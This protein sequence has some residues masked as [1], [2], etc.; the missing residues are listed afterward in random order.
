MDLLG[1]TNELSNSECRGTSR[2]IPAPN[3][4]PQSRSCERVIMRLRSF[5]N[6]DAYSSTTLLRSLYR[7]AGN[8]GYVEVSLEVSPAASHGS[9][10]HLARLNADR[11][12]RAWKCMNQ[13]TKMYKI[14]HRGP[15]AQS[16]MLRKR[17]KLYD[18]LR[19]MQSASCSKMLLGLP[20]LTYN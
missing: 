3:R 1:H 2:H 7:A 14:V 15:V 4:A 19:N 13:Y 6:Y 5:T 16:V 17:T 11:S 9:M 10:S 20:H 12:D 18:N 8:E